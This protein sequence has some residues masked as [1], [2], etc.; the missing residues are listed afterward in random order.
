MGEGGSLIIRHRRGL[1]VADAMAEMQTFAD[2]RTEDDPDELWC[3]EHPPTYTLGLAADPAHLLVAGDIPVVQTDR[4]GEITFHGP[5]QLVVYPLIHLR[6]RGLYVRALVTLLEQSVVRLLH[7]HGLVEARA[8]AKAPGVYLP[9]LPA[10]TDERPTTEDHPP[11][12]LGLGKVAALGLKI[13]K[14][15]ST[16]GLALNLEMDL[17]PFRAI[18]P[19]GYAGLVTLDLATI[20]VRLSWQEAA[21]ELCQIITQTLPAPRSSLA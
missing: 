16:H 2:T 9:L 8:H 15:W 7:Q 18:N 6:R 13:R 12:A 17:A 10:G 11:Q 14:G 21:D 4:G 3:V 20:G 5:G 1:S 19:C